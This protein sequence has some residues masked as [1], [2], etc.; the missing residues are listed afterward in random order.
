MPLQNWQKKYE[1]SRKNTTFAD[2]FKRSYWIA[3]FLAM[4]QSGSMFRINN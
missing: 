1:H 3:S 2:C 4:T